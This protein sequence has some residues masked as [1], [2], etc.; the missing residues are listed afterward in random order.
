MAVPRLS[1]AAVRLWVNGTEKAPDAGDGVKLQEYIN[2]A[3]DGD[4]IEIEGG[5]TINPRSSIVLPKRPVSANYVTI[6]T[7]G[8]DTFC[9][10]GTRVHPTLHGNSLAKISNK[11]IGEATIEMD[12]AASYCRLRGLRI[13]NEV[14]TVNTIVNT[15]RKSLNPMTYAPS[16]QSDFIEFDRCLFDDGLIRI[17]SSGFVIRHDGKRL[18]IHQC[19]FSGY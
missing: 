19:Y 1:E 5:T 14:P 12:F 10:V 17:T 3:Q 15:S 16:D 18:H 11:T 9:P 8:L 13:W 6:A 7:R 2:Q 4:L